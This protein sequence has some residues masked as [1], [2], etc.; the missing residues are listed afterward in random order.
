MEGAV[1]PLASGRMIEDRSIIG[2]KM[3]A[4]FF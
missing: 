1:H 3:P 4:D 2:G